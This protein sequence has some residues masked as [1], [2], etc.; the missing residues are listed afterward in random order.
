MP[1]PLPPYPLGE[2]YAATIA[3]LLLE[4]DAADAFAEL[5]DPARWTLPLARMLAAGRLT[6]VHA[7]LA[8]RW[9][10]TTLRIPNVGDHWAILNATRAF[11]AVDTTTLTVAALR[12]LLRGAARLWTGVLGGSIHNRTDLAAAIRTQRVLYTTPTP[13]ARNAYDVFLT[14]AG[15]QLA[16]YIRA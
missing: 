8:Q 2:P 9:L 1:R 6:P 4:L 5:Q 12:D 3:P 7:G 11:G 16:R 15:D 14:R 13:S 10:L